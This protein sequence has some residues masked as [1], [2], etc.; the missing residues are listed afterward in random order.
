MTEH[1][2]HLVDWASIAVVIGALADWMP[3]LAADPASLS[4]ID[5][6]NW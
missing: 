4:A 6:D 3:S 1:T 2:K 5:S